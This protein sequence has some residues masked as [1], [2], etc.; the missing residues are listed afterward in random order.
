MLL[1][2]VAAC[3]ETASRSIVPEKAVSCAIGR[4]QSLGVVVVRPRISPV[5]SPRKTPH[6]NRLF[7]GSRL[8]APPRA[9]TGP[10]V[11]TDRALGRCEQVWPLLQ[12]SIADCRC[13]G[14]NA[15]KRCA[16]LL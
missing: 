4:L 16:I 15:R 5:G 3:T 9:V 8:R 7:R 1:A 6:E 12:E 14:H 13:L 2:R 10:N 11:V